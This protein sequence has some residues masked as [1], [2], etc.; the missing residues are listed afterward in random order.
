VTTNEVLHWLCLGLFLLL[1]PLLLIRKFRKNRPEWWLI[2]AMTLGLGWLF[3]FASYSFLHLHISDLIEQNKSL[4][5]GWD[6]DGASG[7]VTVY[8][9][10]LLSLIYFLPWLALYLFAAA[11]RRYLRN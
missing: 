10:W 5:D 9:G 8:F 1:P 7:L 4:P 6:S 11:I 2:L 3:L